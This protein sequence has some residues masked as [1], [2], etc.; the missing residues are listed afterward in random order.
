MLM[1]LLALTMTGCA[2]KPK[3]P[4]KVLPPMPER[5]EL[6]PIETTADLV[7]ALNY[8]EHL[9]QEWEAWGETARAIIEGESAHAEP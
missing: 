3:A 2:S 7:E 9:V 4:E 6:A 5:S 1:P 8:Y